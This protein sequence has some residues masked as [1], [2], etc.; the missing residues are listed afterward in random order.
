[1]ALYLTLA[2]T[3][4][5]YFVAHNAYLFYVN[6]TGENLRTAIFAG[7]AALFLMIQYLVNG[8]R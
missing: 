2:Y 3:V 5:T 6:R 7:F 8:L 4:V 1:M